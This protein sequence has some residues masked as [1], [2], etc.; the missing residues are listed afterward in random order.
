M[1]NQLADL[2]SILSNKDA[3]AEEFEAQLK[4][5]GLKDVAECEQIIDDLEIKLK[6]KERKEKTESEKYDLLDV[7]DQFLSEDQIK[8]KRVQKMLKKSSEARQELKKK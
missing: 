1:E 3:D 2:K 7:D 6:L 4:E 8:K 5:R